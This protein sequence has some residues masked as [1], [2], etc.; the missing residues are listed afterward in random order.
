[1]SVKGSHTKSTTIILT[2]GNVAKV[3][4][5]DHERVSK[6]KWSERGGYANHAALGS[7]HKVIIGKRPEGIPEAYVIDHVNRDKLDNRRENLRWVS[8]SFNIFNTNTKPGSS[9]KFRGVRWCIHKEKWIARFRGKSQGSFDNEREAAIAYAKAA[10]RVWPDWAPTS[11]LLVGPDLLSRE[12]IEGKTNNLH[13]DQ[14]IKLLPTGVT[15]K[16]KKYR[17]MYRKEYLGTFATIEQANHVYQ[18]RAAEADA[19]E[20]QTYKNRPIPR[21]KDGDA[22][23]AISGNAGH[24]LSAKVPERFWHCLSFKNKW[25]IRCGYAAGTFEGKSTYLHAVVFRLCHP[26][27][28]VKGSID[29]IDPSDRLNNLESNLRDATRQLQVYNQQKRLNCSSKYIGV[30]FNKKK[31]KWGGRVLFEGK[32][33]CTKWFATE[34]EAARALDSM[35][36]TLMGENA[37]TFV[38]E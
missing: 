31:A 2:T 23:I 15:R 21:D 28:E 1:M 30:Y 10:I 9:S 12:E 7:L 36:K 13:K 14:P 35:S 38:I 11:D 32:R 18:A 4:P 26:D 27:I 3:S 19:A 16:N 34:N 17:A 5:E 22:I 29:H 6:Y 20:W 37:R 25:N 24:G 8:T 33:H